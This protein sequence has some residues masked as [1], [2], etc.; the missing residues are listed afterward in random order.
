MNNFLLVGSLIND[1]HQFINLKYSNE[2]IL[3]YSSYE[4]KIVNSKN[5]S[6]FMITEYSK[7][8][9][10]IENKIINVSALKNLDLEIKRELIN[11]NYPTIKGSIL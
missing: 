4:R 5:K 8:L 1:I 3:Y 10:K 9:K 7:K 11:F 6:F 2:E